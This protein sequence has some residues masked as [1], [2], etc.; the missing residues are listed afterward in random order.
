MST[1]Y[2]KGRKVT[3]EEKA[4]NA[5]LDREHRYAQIFILGALIFFGLVAIFFLNS[6][7]KYSSIDTYIKSKQELNDEL[8]SKLQQLIENDKKRRFERRWDF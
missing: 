2:Y 4:M 3:E 6:G 1:Y 5:L 7:N 8:D